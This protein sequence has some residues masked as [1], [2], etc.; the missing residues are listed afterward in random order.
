MEIDLIVDSLT[1]CLICSATGEEFDTKF[2][3]ISV[4][5]KYASKLQK[6]GWMFDWSVP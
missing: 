6:D 2:R 5:S 3:E 1:N 4:D